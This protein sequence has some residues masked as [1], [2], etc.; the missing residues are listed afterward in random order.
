MSAG[1]DTFETEPLPSDSPLARERR[2]VMS[3][4][5]AALTTESL[6]AMGEMTVQNAL[7]GIDGKLA[8]KNLANPEA[9]D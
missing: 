2:I 1:L 4:H 3:P 6:Q 5:S 7:D 8:R 9:L